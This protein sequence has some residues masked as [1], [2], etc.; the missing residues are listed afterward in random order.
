MA[1][2]TLENAVETT[3]VNDYLTSAEGIYES[4]CWHTAP[5]K[6]SVSDKDYVA[7]SI[8]ELVGF[9]APEVSEEPKEDNEED[10]N[11]E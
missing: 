9:V 5:V 11:N 7:G 6:I 2:N 3:V 8:D 10:N 4:D 1:E